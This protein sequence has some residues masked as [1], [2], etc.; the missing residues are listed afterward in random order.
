M[1]TEGHTV[2]IRPLAGRFGI[3]ASYFLK[4]LKRLEAANMIRLS[5]KKEGS[6]IEILLPVWSNSPHE[7]ES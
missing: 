7:E 3:D 6:Y 4:V 1:G 2:T 5:T